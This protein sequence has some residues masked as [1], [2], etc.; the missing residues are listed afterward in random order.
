MEQ[1]ARYYVSADLQGTD[2]GTDRDY[3]LKQWRGQALEWAYTDEYYGLMKEINQTPDEDLL[4]LIAEFWTLRFRKCRKDK[5]QFKSADDEFWT[6]EQY[7]IE[8]EIGADEE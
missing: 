2:F 8:N 6:Y 1:E 4:G 7:Q 3:T 5:K